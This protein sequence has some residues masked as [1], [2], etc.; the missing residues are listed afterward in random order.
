[1]DKGRLIFH[2]VETSHLLYLVDFLGDLASG[3]YFDF[4][5]SISESQLI[6][7]ITSD[8]IF[9]FTPVL[10]S[11]NWKT[12]GCFFVYFTGMCNRTQ[13]YVLLQ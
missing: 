5:S 2:G 7:W 13:S 6:F 1:M 3:M 8:R 4:C 12:P 10:T 11:V 9:P